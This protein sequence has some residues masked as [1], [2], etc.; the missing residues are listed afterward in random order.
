MRF[1]GFITL[2]CIW[3][4]LSGTASAQMKMVSKEKLESVSNPVLSADSASFL[5]ET[6]HIKA[7]PMNEDEAPAIFRYRFKN[8]SEDELKL[9]RIVTTCSC[10]S[11][12][13][14]VSS[15]APGESSEIIV[16]YDPK[17]HPG[18]FERK[19]FVYS[20]DEASPAAVLRLSVEVVN[21]ADVSNDW[22]IQKG[23]I[24]IRRDNVTFVEGER[25]VEKLRFINLSGK[26]L[27]LTCEESFLPQ[28]LSFRTEPE[29]V[30]DGQTGEMIITYDP[31]KD[32]R[33]SMKIMLKGIGLPPSQSA[34]E[35][36]M[37]KE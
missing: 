32:A 17:G 35:V 20:D 12:S 5:F 22:P 6:R 31:S 4:A 14:P 23:S 28:C 13:C 34:I 33:T 3:T 1:L 15:V 7:E 36:K 8:V 9:S 37:K 27:R 21:G 19:I 29:T 18:R 25:A 26:D 16:R 2:V 30:K 10:A 11:A 24:R